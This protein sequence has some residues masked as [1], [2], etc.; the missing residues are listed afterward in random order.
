MSI[1]TILGHELSLLSDTCSSWNLADDA[2]LIQIAQR[3]S[4]E[5]DFHKVVTCKFDSLY[6]RYFCKLFT[7]LRSY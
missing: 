7:H 3:S 2:L 1:Q 5:S 6:C 4:S